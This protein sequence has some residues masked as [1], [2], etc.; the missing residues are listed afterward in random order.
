MKTKARMALLLPGL[1]MFSIF[2]VSG[3]SRVATPDIGFEFSEDKLGHFLI[4]GLLA[5]TLLRT[6][7]FRAIGLR[8][9]GLAIFLTASFGGLDE[10]RQSFTPGRS[11]EFADWIAD[12]CGAIV[13]SL[14][15]YYWGGYRELL[16]IKVQLR[17]NRDPR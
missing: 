17:R 11:V 4:F 16:E 6:P 2:I 9:V 15:Y 12:S 7:A 5:T 1:L 14:V 13:G 8:G 3:A 10:F